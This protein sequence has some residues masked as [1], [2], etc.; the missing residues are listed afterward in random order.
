F[1][2]G[3]ARA[4]ATQIGDDPVHGIAADLPPA[5]PELG[6]PSAPAHESAQAIVAARRPA[7]EAMTGTLRVTVGGDHRVFVDGHVVGEGP[8]TYPVMWGKHEVQ[9]GSLG[10]IRSLDVPRG[11]E[12][13]LDSTGWKPESIPEVECAWAPYQG[14]WGCGL[15]EGFAQGRFGAP[16]A[17]RDDPG[18]VS[19]RERAWS[20][21]KSAS[22]ARAVGRVGVFVPKDNT[23]MFVP[24][25]SWSPSDPVFLPKPK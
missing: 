19:A 23:W 16:P 8:G 1:H 11:G 6:N 3:A 12:V 21:A 9:V 4:A 2:V 20:A 5:A 10:A 13:V 7:P 15:P 17:F 18:S 25:S 14:A 24:G 22:G